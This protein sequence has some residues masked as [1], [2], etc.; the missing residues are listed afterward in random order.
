MPSSDSGF[1]VIDFISSG[2]RDDIPVKLRIFW[3]LIEGTIAALWVWV[4]QIKNSVFIN[5]S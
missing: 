4:N 2:A 1:L 3:A 5:R